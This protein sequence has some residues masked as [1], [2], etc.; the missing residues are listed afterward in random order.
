MKKLWLAVG[1]PASVLVAA[2]AT[3][4]PPGDAVTADPA[5]YKVLVDNAAV[6]ILKITYGPGEKSPMHVHPDAL[7]VALSATQTK[8]HLPDGATRDGALARDA[9]LYMPA[10]THSPENAGTSPMEAVLIEFKTAAPGSATLP[11]VRDSMTMTLLAEGPRAVAHR[12]TAAPDFAEPEGTTHDYDQV[13]V[14]LGPAD[15]QLAVGGQPARSTW[16]RG[17][18]AFIGRGTPH[19]SKNLSGA[20]V[21]FVIV[22]I[23]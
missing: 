5:H 3:S 20:P 19:A 12:V 13:V 8:F 17:D 10:E 18:V 4:A 22:A 6:R 11:V 16:A 14:A 9:A 15:M 21:E 7:V 2:C 1:L 23:K